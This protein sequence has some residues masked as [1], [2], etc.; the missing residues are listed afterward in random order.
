MNRPVHCHT[1]TRPGA[2]ARR[3][4]AWLLLLSG[5][6]Q[7]VP[8]QA[9]APVPSCPASRVAGGHD[10]QG[11]VLTACS[12]NGLD[13]SKANFAG[14]RLSAVV[15]VR[16]N[17]AGADFSNAT[18]AD[19]G[20]AT[21]PSDFSFADL[22]D[23][24]FIGAKFDGATYLT[25]ATLACSDFSSVNLNTGKAIFGDQALAIVTTR[26][27]RTKFQK[28]TMNCE[29]VPQWS[30]LDL[31]GADITACASL[32]QANG[33]KAGHDF[34]G[35]LYADVVFDGLD[36]TGS[37]WTGAVLERASFQQATLDNAKGLSGAVG[38]L[39]RLSGA[40]FNRASL[41]NVDLSYAALYGAQFTN[42]DLSNSSLAAAA[43]QANPAAQP[44]IQ[45]AAV[46]DGAHLRNVN[47]ADADLEGVSFQYASFYGSFGGGTP[48]IPCQTTCRSPGF[49]C[50]CATA[51]GANLTRANFS[52]A[53]LFGADFTGPTTINGT[54]FDAAILTGASFAGAKFS[55]D[56]GAAPSFG[57]ALLQG[58]TFDANAN[59]PG[60]VFLNAFVDFGRA[61]SGTSGNDLYLQLSA[62]YTRFRGWSGAPKPCV[63]PTYASPSA[64]PAS[65]PM[66]CPD[67]SSG[68]CGNASTPASIARWKS[69]IAMG[70]NSPVPGWYAFDAT[71]DKAGGNPPSCT[72]ALIDPNW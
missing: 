22:T 60:A 5:L 58:A 33:G 14:A 51:S 10:Y 48:Q 26:S 23:A 72:F 4:G 44:P 57:K 37:T 52:N 64:V 28:A 42:A 62:D 2:R 18:F 11:L 29:F 66:T 53:Y 43:L 21:F 49:T 20:S 24:K 3:V 15:F 45:T 34:S 13:L 16:T 56:G 38:K 47:L 32:L 55:V 25:Y 1:A 71:Y 70:T 39:S 36:L 50:A 68:I 67:G 54:Q 17:L 61:G 19:S 65:V 46:F 12:F 27:C 40:R 9:Q 63:R 41:R 7:G 30:Q 59:L 69:G 35:G 8:A 31:S 6:L